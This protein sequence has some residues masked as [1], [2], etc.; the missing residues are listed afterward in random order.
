[1]SGG[2]QEEIDEYR[3]LKGIQNKRERSKNRQRE[4][5]RQRKWMSGG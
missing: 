1:M 5:D 3:S 2:E 4:K